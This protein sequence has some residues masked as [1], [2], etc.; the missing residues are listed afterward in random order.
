MSGR[1]L[2]FSC[3]SN[4]WGKHIQ[5]YKGKL[6]HFSFKKYGYPSY[7]Y[8]ICLHRKRH[9][10]ISKSNF[11][12]DHQILL[13]LSKNKLMSRRL[14]FVYYSINKEVSWRKQ[15]NWCYVSESGISNYCC[16]FQKLSPNKMEMLMLIS[17]EDCI[18]LFSIGD[19]K[20]HNL[21]LAQGVELHWYLDMQWYLMNYGI[22][23]KRW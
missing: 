1:T 18:P 2:W 23:Q 10:A 8:R 4:R 6:C 17:L 16:H 12:S 11:W 21:E 5:C 9:V 14:H 7:K 13:A 15:Q 20:V 19:E 3:M 22:N